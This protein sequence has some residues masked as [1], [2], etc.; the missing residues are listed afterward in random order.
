MTSSPLVSVVIPC[1]NSARY[2]AQA[3]ESVLEQTYQNIELVLVDDCS[4]DNTVELIEGYIKKDSRVRLVRRNKRGGRP[5]ITKN[6]GLQHIR[7]EY[8]C[9]L[10]HDDYYHPS[11]IELLLECFIDHP[12]CVAAFHDVDL[13][14]SKGGFINRYLDHFPVDASEYLVPVGEFA[15]LCDK[16]FYAFQSVRYAAIHTISVM[17]A[18]NRIDRDSIN[19]DTQYKVCDDT[20][21]WIRLGLKG[22]M[23]YLH[24][25]LANYRQ[26]GTNIT[27]DQIKVQEDAL[28]L[29][30]NNFPRVVNT[31]KNVERQ[32][33]KARITHY[34]SDLGWMYRCRYAPWKSIHAYLNAWR[35]SGSGKYILYAAKA[36]FPARSVSA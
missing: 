22:A 29:M 32:A 10:D 24:K 3:V 5:A 28:L 12:E 20:D 21:L 6:T 14:D 16:N 8:V 4:I 36:F 17:I 7:G 19:F 27:R 2:L 34:Y 31:L 35:W 15:Y 23:I 13:V 33:L 25:P 9:F 18:I 26:H 30:E 11:K 1:F